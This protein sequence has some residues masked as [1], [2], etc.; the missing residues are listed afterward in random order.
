M[1][2]RVVFLCNCLHNGGAQRVLVS[3]ANYMAEH[4]YEVYI[5]ASFNNGSYPL[6]E[7]IKV[8]YVGEGEYWK[9][10]KVARKEI[11]QLQ[12]KAVISFEYFFNLLSSIACYGLKTKLIAS[13]RNDP[14]RVGAGIIK[15]RIRNFLYRFIDVLVC[16]TPDAKDYFPSYIKKKSIVIPNPVKP[17]LPVKVGGDRDDVV[18]SFCRLNSQK[19]LPMLLH[20]FKKFMKNHAEYELKIYGDGEEN[21]KLKS[22]SEQLCIRENVGFYPASD[23][24]HELVLNAKMFVLPSDYE[25]LSNSMLEA[26]A[27]GLPIICTDCPCGG[28]R[29]VIKNGEN[30]FLIPVQDTNALYEAMCKI[31]DDNDL[32]ERLSVEAVKLRESLAIEAI[33]QRWMNLF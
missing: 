10:I 29:M 23:N 9:F 12:P 26:M 22:L 20:A 24:V 32:A 3:I 4:S 8:T 14:S 28:A 13:E 33:S 16:Q 11:K 19:N 17:N 25:G 21:E 30:G 5:I 6:S 15:D 1:Q 27:I 2:K 31:A 7:N 18:V